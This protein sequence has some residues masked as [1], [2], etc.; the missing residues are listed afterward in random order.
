MPFEQVAS[1][2]TEAWPAIMM[3]LFAVLFL[4]FSWLDQP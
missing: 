1:A 3:F 4:F 2:I